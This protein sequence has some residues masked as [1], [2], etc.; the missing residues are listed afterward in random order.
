MNPEGEG[1]KAAAHYLVTIAPGESAVLRLRLRAANGEPAK[2]SA[3]GAEASIGPDFDTVFS[4][5]QAEADEFYA[6]LTPPEL[7]EDGALV[8][9]QAMAGMLWT[10]QCYTYDVDR[11][12]RDRGAKKEGGPRPPTRNSNWFH[13]VNQDIISMPDKWEYPWFAAWDLAFHTIALSMVDLDFAKQQLELM[14]SENYMHPNGQTARLRVG[15]RRREP[16]GA[17][18]GGRLPLQPRAGDQRRGGPGVPRADV[19]QAAHD[20]HLVGQPQGPHRQQRVRGRLPR[21][22]Q[23]RR[24][25]PER[26]PA[27]RRLSGAGRRHGL[28]GLLLPEHAVHGREAG[29][30]QPGLRAAGL[31]VLRALPLDRRGHGPHGRA[32]RRDVGPGGRL[33]LRSAPPARRLRHPVESALLGRAA[34]AVREQRLPPRRPGEAAQ[35]Q[36]AGRLVHAEPSRTRRPTSR[37]RP[38]KTAVTCLRS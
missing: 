22:G 5:R 3:P 8:M 27:H 10:K 15:L 36:R 16:A 25:R 20:L 2:G 33:L 14:L 9:R 31:Q 30:R 7:G 26:P 19:R 29:H 24:V 12:L 17:C 37:R 11:W 35:V 28:D 13:M 1:T 4:A 32:R 23:H 18:L 21:P 34:L 6:S 38:S